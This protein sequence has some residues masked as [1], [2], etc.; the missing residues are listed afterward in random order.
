MSREN[1]HLWSCILEKTSA[2][3]ESSNSGRSE[4]EKNIK[5]AYFKSDWLQKT[6]LLFLLI[7]KALS[8]YCFESAG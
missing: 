8:V 6:K 5:T 2:Q 3:E 4:R 7:L 1:T